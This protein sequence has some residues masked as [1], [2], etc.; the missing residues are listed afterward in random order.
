[1][2]TKL[3]PLLSVCLYLAL[4]AKAFANF[5]PWPHPYFLEG[6]LLSCPENKECL[7]PRMDDVTTLK[8]DWISHEEVRLKRIERLEVLA[9]GAAEKILE[10]GQSEIEKNEESIFGQTYMDYGSRLLT[11]ISEKEIESMRLWV[12]QSSPMFL[13]ISEIEAKLVEWQNQIDQQQDPDLKEG[14][15]LLRNEKYKEWLESDET[16][17]VLLKMKEVQLEVFPKNDTEEGR[18]DLIVDGLMNLSFNLAYYIDFQECPKKVEDEITKHLGA[19]QFSEGHRKAGDLDPVKDL[20]FIRFVLVGPGFGK[21]LRVKCDKAGFL[22][23]MKVSYEKNHTLEVKFK[24]KK[25]GNGV[26]QY[27]VPS[28]SD[29][30][31]VLK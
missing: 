1:M 2:N 14:L 29:I 23:K 3:Y 31:S 4:S 9:R 19:V 7:A 8:S 13:K 28:R 6:G 27:R 10:I 18:E 17:E 20:N 25:D 15:I 26:T 11:N 30:R 5:G 24:M 21:P 16:Q 12:S 22:A